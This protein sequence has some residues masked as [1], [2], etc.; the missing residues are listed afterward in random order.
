MPSKIFRLIFG[1]RLNPFNKNTRKHITLIAFFAWVG[2]GA[3]ALSSSCYGPEEAY[4]A[5]GVNSHLAVYIALATVITIFIISLGYS[6]VIQLF[7]SGGGGYKVV[8]KL[9]HPYA[10]LVAG[11][12]LIVDYVLTIA[13][14]IASGV[15]ALL[16]FLPT[17]WYEYQ[18]EIKLVIILLMLGLNLRGL[19]EAITVLIP[20]FLGFVIVHVG[21]IIYGAVSHPE[22]FIKIIPLAI[23]QTHDLTKTI[24][25]VAVIGLVLHA[26]SLGAGTYTGLESVANNVYQ[27]SE[28]RVETG[29][30]TMLYMSVSLS[31]M[32]GGIMLL[33]LLWDV[34]A[35][36]GQTLNAVV[37][38]N[39]LG[40]S[41]VA[42]ILLVLALFLEGGL[43]FVAANAGFMGG[44]AVLANMAT[45]SWM[46]HRFFHLSDR[47]VI[48]N[49]LVLL[50]LAA[51]A[52]LLWSNGNVS[53]LVILYSI[54]VFITFTLALLSIAVYWATH[55]QNAWKWQF[56]NATFG[57]MTTLSI[58]CI[59]LYYKF[60]QG[61]WLTLMI[62]ASIIIFSLIIKNHYHQLNI[63]LRSLDKK[64]ILPLRKSV[65]TPPQLDPG[66]PTAVILL[67]RSS[68][69]AMHTLKDALRIFP[70]YFHNIVFLNVGVVDMRSFQ[71]ETELEEMQV[72][73]N[74]TLDYFVKYA[75]ENGFAAEGYTAFA[76]QPMP[77]LERMA[78]I[79][80]QKYPVCVFFAGKIIFKRE[81]ILTD[82]LFDQAAPIFQRFLNSKGKELMILPMR[83]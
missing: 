35:V 66:K 6:Q 52:I 68:S 48:Q 74:S 40:D 15:D 83:V 71:G 21:L 64:L 49:S 43:L 70:D 22:G 30:R 59:T 82:F 4:L 51:V 32:A 24:G 73:V 47:L 33:Y 75:Q 56:I 57:F 16:S 14:S 7:P 38:H 45:D 17:H 19:K 3:D 23:T 46:P 42:K 80:W 54:N 11:S 28:P 62:T 63:R 53:L 5:L 13:V 36:H 65:T 26:Y 2:L 72:K 29:K 79:V 18:L 58:L 20:V 25:L 69:M 60:R 78:R 1:S 34:H 12:A 10:G 37:F 9:L 55:R 8:T 41:A 61:G 67:G 50:G 77:E 76:Q 81:N 44:P 39:I 31:V 27:L